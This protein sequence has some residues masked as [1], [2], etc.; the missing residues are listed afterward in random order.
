MAR[1]RVLRGPRQLLERDSEL[2]E[3]DAAIAAAAEEE[4]AF[5]VLEGRSGMGKSAL[6]A[7]VRSRAAA[8]GFAICSARGSELEGEFAFGVVR[9]LFEPAIAGL[10]TEERAHVFEGAGALAEP[11]LDIDGGP[12]PAGQFAALHGLYWLA[13]NLSAR[14][15]LLLSVDD[16]HW[17]DAASLRWLAYTLNRLEGLP[18]LVAVASRPPQ[19]GR[20]G[21][22]LAAILAHPGVRIV[23]V[24]P[25]GERSVA[26]LVRAT[27]G[28]EPDRIF[29]A[30]CLR[31]TAGNPL[32]LSELLR[33]LKAGGVAPS[34]AAAT[35]LERRAPDAITR[36]V[37]RD[38]SLLGDDAER[39]A[40]A[41]AVIEDG[42]AL[43]LIARLAD[44][45]V[46][47]AA[48]AADDLSAADLIAPE[49]PPRFAHPLLR[50]AVYDRL[51]AGARQRLHRRAA[52]ILASEG[53]DPEVLA[54]HLLRCDA[55]QSVE[56]VGWLRAAAPLALRRGA[57]EAAVS[58]LRRALAEDVDAALRTAVR[59]ELGRAELASGDRAATGHLREA[60]AGTTDRRSRGAILSDLAM[61]VLMQNDEPACRALLAGAL[62]ELQTC[63]PDASAN[64]ECVIAGMSVGDPRLT[65]FVDSHQPRLREL[66]Q[67][68][69]ASA[70]LARVTLLS[71]LSFRDG[72]LAEAMAWLERDFDATA[73][74]QGRYS[75]LFGVS[76]SMMALQGVD[77]PQR[78]AGWCEIVMRQAAADGYPPTVLTG[79]VFKA[80]AECRLGLLAEAEAD[81]TAAFELSQHL[82][83][84]WAP[85]AGA[86]LAEILLEQGR[87]QTARN[88]M[89]G[90][91]L[92]PG[93]TGGV[94]EA[95]LTQ[96]RGRVRCATVSQQLGLNDLRA[97]GRL[98]EAL[99]MTNP[100]VWRWR[101]WLAS[102]LAQDCPDEARQL[103]EDHLANARRSGLLGA[104]GVALRLLAGLDHSNTIDLLR[105]SVTALQES[106]RPLD[107]ARSL[108][109]L[110]AA[111]RRRGHRFEAREPLREALEIAARCGSLPIMEEARGEALAAGARPR[112]PRLR[113]VEALTPSE[114]RVARLAA[115]G[116][117]NREIAQALFITTNTVADHLGRSYSKL[118]ITS[119][120]Q[121]KSAL[122]LSSP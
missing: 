67:S 79:M 33:E 1:E 120:D 37:L 47:R 105:A 75:H 112:R 35:E 63:D 51:S 49:H 26:T 78:L 81:A 46:D 69:T 9:Q 106:P 65:P 95:I 7:E 55:G 4:G 80:Y 96:V 16:A 20:Q 70:E 54:A 57:P 93:L 24:G 40:S 43:R 71:V 39:L 89:E 99:R 90:I 27:L 28:A 108:T 98:C 86:Y 18:I 21:E 56:S 61:A 2:S 19:S 17:A 42:G 119:R 64:L 48:K 121:L 50:A 22:A 3:I 45:E 66:A 29:T 59:A 74:F 13:A 52:Q 8:G 32:G 118:D 11:V 114:L 122:S 36:R 107:L 30:G 111:L 5:L 92:G 23:P 115:E 10:S 72:N 91:T 101:E 44:L 6:L 62:G 102:E 41:L 73:L 53:A 100:V 110:G 68:G 25:L 82:M 15:P 83:P 104:I 85:V 31:A 60:L 14:A 103:A 94:T 76:W 109:E 87:R 34:R 77:D 58:Y 116:R 88:L 38:L 84:F 117:S 97:S 12:G 113:G